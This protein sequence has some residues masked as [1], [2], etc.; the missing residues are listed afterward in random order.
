MGD[1]STVC[2]DTTDRSPELICQQCGNTARSVGRKTLY[3]LLEPGVARSVKPGN[4]YGVCRTRSCSIL[5]FSDNHNQTWSPSDVR[6]TVGFKQPPNASP[7]P[8]CYCFG[9][10]EKIIA[11]ELETT[12]D[13]TVVEWIT[14]RVQAGECACE[15]KNPTGRCCL[16]NV[17]EAVENAR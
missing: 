15:Y 8:V 3:H 11:E 2:G 16:G 9:Y 6:S 14:E 1:D 4:K 5:Y 12:G 7:T 10:T 13:S 17:R